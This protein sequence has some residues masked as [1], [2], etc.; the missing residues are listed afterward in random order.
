MLADNVGQ[1]RPC[2]VPRLVAAQDREVDL[3]TS[4]AACAG[5]QSGPSARL[6]NAHR[7]PDGPLLWAVGELGIGLPAGALA[8]RDHRRHATVLDLD[9]RDLRCGIPPELGNLTQFKQQSLAGNRLT[10]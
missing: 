5:G 3:A 9:Y 8:G 7:R 2:E 1:I 6:R 4:I 10:G